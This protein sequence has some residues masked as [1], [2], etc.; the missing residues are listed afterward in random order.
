MEYRCCC[1]PSQYF[2]RHGDADPNSICI[3][4]IVEAQIS[5]EAIQMKGNRHKML[6]KLRAIMILDKGARV[7]SDF[8]PLI[9]G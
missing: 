7:V 8:I 9:M 1:R 6:V 4:D 5:F 3:G 2:N